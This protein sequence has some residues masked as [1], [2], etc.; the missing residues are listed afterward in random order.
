MADPW[1][2]TSGSSD[3]FGMLGNSMGYSAD[4]QG[5]F[6][7]YSTSANSDFLN[8]LAAQ[9]RDDADRQYGLQKTKL[10]QDYKIAQMNARTASE[11]NA[12]DKWYNQ[13]QVRLAE[14][15]LAEDQR[16]FNTKT[17]YELVNT[18]AGLRGPANFWQASNFSRGVA[19]LPGTPAFLA[20]LQ[21]N[22]GLAPSAYGAQA[23]APTPES[24]GTL[25]AKL[26]GDTSGGTNTGGGVSS[27]QVLAGLS[28]APGGGGGATG[29][30][31]AAA[32]G[33]P[34]SGSSQTDAALGAIKAIGARG[35]QGLIPGSLES[36]SPTELEL[37]K[38]GLEQ[39][40]YDSPTFLWQ[41]ANSRVGNQYN[42]GKVA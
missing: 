30:A 15:R 16:Q 18:L 9:Q 8:Q 33:G 41:Y 25:L 39:A 31:P 38:G 21:T 17:G 40:G 24:Y 3:P 4:Q 12:I 23:G 37:F 6:P 27:N 2:V 20:A 1:F 34:S 22:T 28:A 11:R 35:A 10:D 42:L 5:G 19:N 32:G 13:Q 26:G 7:G 36:L 14:M 29:A